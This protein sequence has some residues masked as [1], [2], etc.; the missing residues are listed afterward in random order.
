MKRYPINP[1]NAELSANDK[2]RK[3]RKEAAVSRTTKDGWGWGFLCGGASLLP[4][5]F[6]HVPCAEICVAFS[7]APNT[8]TG[9]P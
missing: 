4:T 1:R 3:K 6:S 9:A 8:E 2:R 7:A 5:E